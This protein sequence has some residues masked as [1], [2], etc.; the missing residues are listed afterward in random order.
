M[1]EAF[2]V[3]DA[4]VTT[5]APVA[6]GDCEAQTGGVFFTMVQVRVAELVPLFNVAT[7]VLLPDVNCEEVTLTNAA[8]LPKD[9]PFNDQETAQLASFTTTAKAVA[10]EPA[11]ATRTVAVDGDADVTLQLFCTVKFH[12]H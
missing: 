6:L 12:E 11:E 8:E 9:V 5:V 3:N 1:P 7:S 4:E 10:V 2:K